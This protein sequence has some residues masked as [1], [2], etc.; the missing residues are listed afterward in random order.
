MYKLLSSNEVKKIAGTGATVVTYDIFKRLDRI[1][2]L[3]KNG[4]T[5]VIVL[6]RSTPN[7]GHWVG[8]NM[9]NPH[10]LNYFDSYGYTVDKPLLWWKNKQS[11]KLKMELGQEQPFLSK[12]LLDFLDEDPRN[13]VLFNEYRFQGTKKKDSA[14]CGRHVG[15]RLLHSDI[16]LEKYQQFWNDIKRK[17][18]PDEVVVELT[19]TMI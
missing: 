13:K 17:R 11:K 2:D 16:P 4:I 10:L 6:Y 1:Q 5:K 9:S 7:T 15:L 12:L 19:A 18:D 14:V 8:L 3:F